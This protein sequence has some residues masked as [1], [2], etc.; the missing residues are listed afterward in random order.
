M[1][2][3]E[4]LSIRFQKLWTGLWP[5]ARPKAATAPQTG[6][7]A[8]SRS[9]GEII[10]KLTVKRP[11]QTEYTVN[12]WK[13]AV[14]QARDPERPRNEPIVRLFDNL[15]LTDSHLNA[16]LHSRKLRVLGAKWKVTKAE[17]GDS[18]PQAERVLRGRWFSDLM[19]YA[20]DALFH[21]HSLIELDPPTNG[22]V[23]GCR[24]IPRMY[25]CQQFGT[26][27]PD[28][29]L[30]TSGF[31]YRTDEY[32][33][34]VEVFPPAAEEGLL[35]TAAPTSLLKKVV[36]IAWSRHA[37]IFG[38]PMRVAKT[39]SRDPADIADIVEWL[40]EMG[41]AAYA[42][43]PAGTDV[44]FVESSKTDAYRIYQEFVSLAD[45]QI[46]KLVLG[47]TMT[48]DEGA[49]GTR[50]QGLVHQSTADDY[51]AADK[52]FVED[53][54]NTSVLPM[55]ASFGLPV[56]GMA[57]AFDDAAQ[58]P[59]AEQ[60][61][62]DR[63]LIE[64]GYKLPASYLAETY[65]VPIEGERQQPGGAGRPFPGAVRGIRTAIGKTWPISTA[66]VRAAAGDDDAAGERI[67][68]IIVR[69]GKLVYDGKA[70]ESE[71]EAA[72]LQAELTELLNKAVDVGYGKEF[73]GIAYDDP[74]REALQWLRENVNLFSA[75]KTQT[76]LDEINR[77]LLDGDERRP[78]P[79]FRDEVLKLHATYNV[80]YLAAEYNN[81][82]ACSQN[83]SFWRQIQNE[84]EDL[85]FLR[86]SAVRD[87][88]TRYDHGQLHGV[89]KRVDDPFWES[90]YPPN[91]WNCRCT[92]IQVADAEVT[93]ADKTPSPEF[94]KGEKMF[95]NN[96]GKTYA[97]FPESHP[98][99]ANKAAARG[100]AA[101]RTFREAPPVGRSADVQR[102]YRQ[103]SEDI[104][105]AF[106]EAVYPKTPVDKIARRY[107]NVKTGGFYVTHVDHN[108]TAKR[109]FGHTSE[110]ARRLADVG[111]RIVFQSEKGSTVKTGDAD[112]NGE[113]WEF[114][115]VSKA[116][117]I[118]AAIR[119]AAKLARKQSNRLV[120]NIVQDIEP[121]ALDWALWNIARF[122]NSA[123]RTTPNLLR[124]IYVLLPNGTP[125]H[126]FVDEIQRPSGD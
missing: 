106:D 49:S 35:F 96:V 25:V 3:V 37:E 110:A 9:G 63:Q 48:T 59:K 92:V 67:Y 62:I 73:Q 40:Q 107:F 30:P 12:E 122:E 50:A 16:V 114:K 80:N 53:V 111:H 121:D 95:D 6:Q 66:G 51:L 83:A 86:Y 23:M 115:S 36:T 24:L 68:N 119:D 64:L 55:L 13:S 113:S 1:K 100:Y 117:N 15:L 18:E 104:Y 84:A 29:M 82:V 43:F 105:E 103:M 41:N 31:P 44:T 52:R 79:A 99:Q 98:Y 8:F 126:Y 75:A 81:T 54:V 46:S 22:A 70:D 90:Y 118:L 108:A 57:F 87:E 123:D 71:E 124:E 4:S 34:L 27:T 65:N 69:L 19:A 78:F 60:F 14:S 101:G 116:T 88:R 58:L 102:R 33:T 91:G 94:R 47:Q 28:P 42:L 97:V 61:S 56:A 7:T 10:P 26:I 2:P 5:S 17:G 21:G 93:P 77:L 11:P 45:K 39:D 74:D 38:M 89:V 120:L 32:R 125:K 20:M 72:K 109:N 85:P 112:I 76:E